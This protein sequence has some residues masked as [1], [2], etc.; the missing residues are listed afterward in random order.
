MQ[1]SKSVEINGSVSE[2]TIAEWLARGC[3]IERYYSVTAY[4]QRTGQ[5]SQ[6]EIPVTYGAKIRDGLGVRY[7]FPTLEIWA[8]TAELTGKARVSGDRFVTC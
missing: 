1:R 4:D 5:R 6:S 8:W 3:K 7:G 2:L